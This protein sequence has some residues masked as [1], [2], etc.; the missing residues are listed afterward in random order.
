MMRLA[1]VCWMK[2]LHMPASTPLSRTTRA[3]SSVIPCRPQRGGRI[4]KDLVNTLRAVMG[5]GEILANAGH[6]GDVLQPRPLI[7]VLT[8]LHGKEIRDAGEQVNDECRGRT[9]S[10]D[11]EE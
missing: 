9:A 1:E 6:F 11:L 8:R 10:L 4:L 7:S 2:T 5:L 3:T